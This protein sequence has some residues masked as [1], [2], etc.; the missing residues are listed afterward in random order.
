MTA[1]DQ[2]SRRPTLADVAKA[3][4]V[5]V[6][7]ASIA[8][9]GSGPVSDATRQRVL[10]AA[11]SLGYDGPDPRARSLRQGRSGVIGVVLEGSLLY[12]FRDPVTSITL[13]GVATALGPQGA[14]ILLLTDSGEG[15]ATIDTAAVDA[16]ILLGC[17]TRVDHSIE[18]FGRRDIPVVSVEGP[19]RPELVEVTLDNRAASVVAARHLQ[20]LGHERVG[21]ATLGIADGHEA[22]PVIDDV[23][24]AVS[25]TRERLLGTRE[26]YPDAPAFSS[27]HNT[28]EDGRRAALALLGAAERPT[29][30]V[31]QADLLAVGVIQAV[32]ELGLVVGVDVSVIGFDGIRIDGFA[33]DLTTMVQPASAKGHAAGAAV[34]ALLSGERPETPIAFTCELHVGS[35]TGPVPS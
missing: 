17:S 21:I 31:A 23:E 29:A 7:T 13:D 26:V 1:S 18:V 2:H 35:T 3:A 34:T 16:V 12:A 30:I 6:S 4:G 27:V 11:A 25:V 10:A 5:S 8:F 19:S 28:P 15:A 22:G 24:I 9:S 33:H 32:E 14:G 20:S